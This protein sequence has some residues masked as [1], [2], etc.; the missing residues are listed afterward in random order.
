VKKAT[1][2]HECQVLGVGWF[3]QQ[4]AT[5]YTFTDFDVREG[6]TDE[7]GI[8]TDDSFQSF[9]ASHSGDFQ[10]ITD[11][12]AD[13]GDNLYTRSWQDEDNEQCFLDLVYGDEE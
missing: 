1:I 13:I 8:I 11:F 4:S 2:T 6:M 7:V 10:S 12:N 3:G 5:T 9:L